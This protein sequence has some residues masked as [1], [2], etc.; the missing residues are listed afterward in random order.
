MTPLLRVKLEKEGGTFSRSRLRRQVRSLPRKN[1]YARRAIRTGQHST[2]VVVWYRA[3][4]R[5]ESGRA[6]TIFYSLRQTRQKQCWLIARL[7]L[8]ESSAAISRRVDQMADRRVKFYDIRTQSLLK[9]HR[10]LHMVTTCCVEHAACSTQ[11]TTRRRPPCSSSTLLYAER[12]SHCMVS[13]IHT[14]TPTPSLNADSEPRQHVLRRT[15]PVLV[16]SIRGV[17]MY[18]DRIRVCDAPTDS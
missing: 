9:W 10:G 17:R 8:Q 7:A 15:I 13:D 4:D 12:S 16:R 1:P 5:D 11:Q 14:Q 3:V 6:R 2:S 18:P